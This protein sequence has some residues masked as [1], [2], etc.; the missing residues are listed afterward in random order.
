MRRAIG[1]ALQDAAIDPLMTGNELLRLQA[2]LHGHPQVGGARARGR[3]AGERWASPPAGNRRVGA[4]S[5]GMRRRLDLALA[6]IHEPQVLFLDE[7]TTGLDPM[8]SHRAVGRGALSQPRARHDGAAHD[9]VPGGGR[10]AGRAHRHHRRRPHRARGAPRRSQGGGRV[11]HAGCTGRSGSVRE[12]GRRARRFR[13][14]RPA[15]QGLLAVGLEGGAGQMA[16]VVLALDERRDHR[17]QHGTA[18][19]DARRRVR[20]SH[21]PSP[22]RRRRRRGCR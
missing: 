20:G 10:P 22:R 15:G 11:S 2:T 8:S 13:P 3:A 6:L 9:P 17:G 12:G 14:D 18:Q 7:P 21:R 19:P 16:E 5:G 1:V 4:Y